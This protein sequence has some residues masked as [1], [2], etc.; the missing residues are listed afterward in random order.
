MRRCQRDRQAICGATARSAGSIP[1]VAHLHNSQSNLSSLAQSFRRTNCVSKASLHSAST[2]C[3][4]LS[5]RQGTGHDLEK[6]AAP[7]SHTTRCGGRLQVTLGSRGESVRLSRTAC[8]SQTAGRHW[9]VAPY[10]ARCTTRG[11]T[12]D[13]ALLCGG[14]ELGSWL[15]RWLSWFHMRR[16]ACHAQSTG[17]V[18]GQVRC[19]CRAE[20]SL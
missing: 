8:C 5:V 1:V 15:L 2:A 14:G 6:A 18:H 7:C 17:H 12:G 16:R 13:A 11:Q 20:W 19:Q 3:P 9:H 10:A 4:T